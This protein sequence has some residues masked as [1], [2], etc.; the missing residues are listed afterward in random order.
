MQ[1]IGAISQKNARVRRQRVQVPLQ[2]TLA[3]PPVDQVYIKPAGAQ[4]STTTSGPV[5][6]GGGLVALVGTAIL[7]DA[8]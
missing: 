5:L 2:E 8:R 7:K 6:P 3:E 4:S 1:S